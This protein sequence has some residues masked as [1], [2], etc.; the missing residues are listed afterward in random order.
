M[1]KVIVGNIGVVIE[2]A[3]EQT[4]RWTFDEYVKLSNEP[5][6]RCT[7]EP[8]TFMAGDEIL[9]DYQPKPDMVE[10]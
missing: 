9:L 6:G 1:F 3:D 5:Y 10:A 4:A 7:G 8:V 2:T